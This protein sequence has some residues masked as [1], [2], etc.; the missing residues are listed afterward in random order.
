MS[1]RAG[2]DL[3]QPLKLPSQRPVIQRGWQSQ[4]RSPEEATQLL[5]A[6]RSVQPAPGP[7]RNTARGCFLS[8]WVWLARYCGK[9]SITV[10]SSFARRVLTLPKAGATGVWE[11][12]R[13]CHLGEPGSRREG[14]VTPGAD[15]GR[16]TVRSWVPWRL[17][18]IPA[19]KH[20]HRPFIPQQWSPHRV[21]GAGDN[22]EQDSAACLRGLYKVKVGRL[23]LSK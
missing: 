5:K 22:G 17:R 6:Q 9:A 23:I 11:G 18:S 12:L 19:S 13:G 8:G 20:M 2:E 14:S 15:V 1:A 3:E 7:G 10:S 21:R 16:V 4:Q